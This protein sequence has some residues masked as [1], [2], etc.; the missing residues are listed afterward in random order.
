MSG[1]N[2][3]AEPLGQRAYPNL[4]DFHPP[5]QIDGN[6]G[7]AAGVC[8]MLL[9]SHLRSID[10]EADSIEKAAFVAYQ[11]DASKPNHFVPVVPDETL[12]QAPYILH[13]LPALP[14]AWPNGSVEGL[15]ARGGFEVDIAW[16]DGKLTN[17]AVRS[18]NGGTFRLY[19]NGELSAN[20]DLQKGGSF[21]WRE[22]TSGK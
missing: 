20:I 17:A 5:F 8:E 4:F 13:L 21:S 9:Q 1:A 18:E 6:F 14:S 3:T 22:A 10:A 11:K 2:G 15:R 12:A 16:A 7:G 19:A